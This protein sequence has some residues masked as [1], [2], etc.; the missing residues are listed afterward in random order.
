MGES[1]IEGKR[2]TVLGK[3]R[4]LCR[5]KF[6]VMVDG[7]IKA[8]GSFSDIFVFLRS[9]GFVEGLDVLG[10][11]ADEIEAPRRSFTGKKGVVSE[12]ESSIIKLFGEEGVITNLRLLELLDIEKNKLDAAVLGL[13]TRGFI[14]MVGKKEKGG[15]VVQTYQL[16]RPGE[17]I[18]GSL[19]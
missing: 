13:Q 14:R 5:G 17:I 18:A 16:T 2:V 15:S 19:I 1:E 3:R 12:F 7:E 10:S 9:N 8:K 11:V 6:G 4:P